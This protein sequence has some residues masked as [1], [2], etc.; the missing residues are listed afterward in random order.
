MLPVPLPSRPDKSR[1]GGNA[2]GGAALR[3][4]S[5]HG[6]QCYQHKHALQANISRQNAGTYR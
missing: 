2:L 6:A 1:I 4:L 5:K 3:L